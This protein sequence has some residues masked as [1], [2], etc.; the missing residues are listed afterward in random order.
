MSV[1]PSYRG[2]YIEET[3]TK[4]RVIS[5]VTTGVASKITPSGLLDGG[6]KVVQTQ[7]EPGGLAMLFG[8]GNEHVL[9]RMS[10]YREGNSTEGHMVV[11]FVGKLP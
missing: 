10:D 11:T 4:I 5:G 1:T 7:I 2:V 3:S 8:K 6:Y 9:I